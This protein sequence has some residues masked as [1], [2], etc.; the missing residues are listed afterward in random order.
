M[1]ELKAEVNL[2]ENA[3]YM[4]RD[5]KLEKLDVPGDGYGKQTITWQAGKPVHYEVSY[6]KK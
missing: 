1:A 6:T 3:V 5:G 4:V 2:L